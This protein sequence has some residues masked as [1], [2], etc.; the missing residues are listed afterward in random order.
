MAYLPD[1]AGML[2]PK[3]PSRCPYCVEGGPECRVGH[4]HWRQ[5]K[6]GPCHPLEVALCRVHGRA[7]TLYPPGHRPYG[8]QA[9]VPLAPDGSRLLGGEEGGTSADLFEAE[10]AGGMFD[11]ALDAA[12]GRAWPRC[13]ERYGDGGLVRYWSGQGR[14]IEQAMELVGVA[15]GLGGEARGQIAD[16]L[17]VER[18]LLD[19]QA[20][21][22]RDALGYRS[23]GRAVCE[24]LR[25]MPP[26]RQR[27]QRLLESGR[28]A[29]LWGTPWHCDPRRGA[30]VRMP[31]RVS[32]P[33]APP[34]VGCRSGT[35]TKVGR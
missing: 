22:V 28:A 25:A 2:R 18:M 21:A 14:L 3:L 20:G 17:G 30:L 16:V 35:S 7:F 15:P 8:R 19:E 1:E 9:V 24:V 5:R 31:F 6:T 12:A 33:R 32:G 23:R 13:S 11:A 10:L 29:G 4:H 26:S 34:P 27:Y